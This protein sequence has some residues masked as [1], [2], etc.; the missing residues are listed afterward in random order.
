MALSTPGALR[1]GQQIIVPNDAESLEAAAAPT[2]ATTPLP[3]EVG[4]LYFG[5][6]PTG[7]LW[8]L[9]E[10]TNPGPE[11]LEGVK[12]AVSLLDA[13]GQALSK[14]ETLVELDML[15]PGDSG[16][17]ALMFSP[18]P[19]A[20]ASYLAEAVSAYPA[21]VGGYYRDLDVVDASGEGERYRAYRVS[22]RLAQR[23]A[24]GC[25]GCQCCRRS[26]RRLGSCHRFPQ[27][28]TGS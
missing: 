27:R 1:I 12:V 18:P 15:E 14:G 11:T 3:M 21:Y 17:F 9:G 16:P 23:R 8:A 26:L 13:A 4:A 20:F 2:A 22:G 25:C 28:C 24:R 19:P 5:A 7:G 6:S 10:V